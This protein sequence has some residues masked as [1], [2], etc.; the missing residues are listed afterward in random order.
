MNAITR[1]KLYFPHSCS[2]HK[3][4]SLIAMASQYKK[5]KPQSSI[6]PWRPFLFKHSDLLAKYRET[7]QIDYKNQYRKP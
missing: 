4:S 5:F 6:G 1:E 2:F 3:Y 7:N